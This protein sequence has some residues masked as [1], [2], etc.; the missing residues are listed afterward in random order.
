MSYYLKYINTQGVPKNTDK[1]GT[2]KQ[3]LPFSSTFPWNKELKSLGPW[4]FR[5]EKQKVEREQPSM[6]LYKKK[7]NSLYEN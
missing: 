7:V 2:N 1:S 6:C 5:A 3:Y 4:N